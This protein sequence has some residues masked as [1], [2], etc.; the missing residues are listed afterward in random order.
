[1]YVICIIAARKAA[2]NANLDEMVADCMKDTNSDEEL[3]EGDDDP[4]LLVHDKK[5]DNTKFVI[6]YGVKFNYIQKI[7]FQ[8]ELK[9]L[10]GDE[11]TEEVQESEVMEEE[12]EESSNRESETKENNGSVPKLIKLLQERLTMYEMAEQKAKNEKES[13]K[14][15][16]YNRGV[17][18]LKGM[19]T[20]V[21]SGR[22]INE[23]EIPPL[24]PHSAITAKNIGK[25]I[26]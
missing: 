16:R 8:K 14:V 10:T 23:D 15:R 19:I 12:Q 3:S 24:L 1:M 17:K 9:I 4:A 7:L 18:I 26:R 20:S 13:G 11:V 5:F 6:K 21:Q 22:N 2:A 25:N